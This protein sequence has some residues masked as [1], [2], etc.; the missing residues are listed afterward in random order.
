MSINAL[1]KGPI[2]TKGPASIFKVGQQ[3]K[4][5]YVDTRSM[6]A[7]VIDSHTPWDWTIDILPNYTMHQSHTSLPCLCPS[8]LGISVRPDRVPTDDT[9]T[10]P[11]HSGSGS[12]NYPIRYNHLS[13]TV[14][15]HR[16]RRP[17]P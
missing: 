15:A 9:G 12:L 5:F 14:L 11:D 7:Q 2:A 10:L 6:F 16:C 8:D 4:V 13:K 3:T 1:T 17:N